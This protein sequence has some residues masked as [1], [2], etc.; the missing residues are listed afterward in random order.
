MNLN[1]NQL[2]A[3]LQQDYTTVVVQFDQGDGIYG[4]KRYTY[5]VPKVWNVKEGDLVVVKTPYGTKL[6]KVDV[7]HNEPNLDFSVSAGYKW[8]IQKVDYT[9]YEGVMEQEQEMA[10]VLVEVERQ[11]Q[12]K[13]LRDEM[14]EHLPEGSEERKRVEE[15]MARF[16]SVKDLA[17]GPVLEHHNNG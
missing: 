12:Q 5:K 3:L 14:L 7:V 9:F 13:K 11:K 6:V 10:K 2:I 17:G 15:A 4:G 16:K 1:P 8:A